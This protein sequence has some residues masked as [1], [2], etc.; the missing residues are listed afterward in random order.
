MAGVGDEIGAHLLG[1]AGLAEVGEPDEAAAVGQRRG[2]QRP[3]PVAAAEA[4][5]SV[6]IGTLLARGTKQQFGGRRVS[7]RQAD[8]GAL[9]VAA[10][11]AERASFAAATRPSRTTSIGSSMARS[12][13]DAGKRIAL[14]AVLG[15]GDGRPLAPRGE[16]RP[17]S[18]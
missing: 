11:Q 13:R 16:K 14:F 12:V 8:V 7:D 9:D 6:F 5:S 3:L 2:G 1:G 18:R 4:T 15:D 17:R 10:E